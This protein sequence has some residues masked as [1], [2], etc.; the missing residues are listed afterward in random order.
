MARVDLDGGVHPNSRARV[1]N[2]HRAGRTTLIFA[3]NP[4]YGAQP[5]LLCFLWVDTADKLR[6]DRGGR[7]HRR[8]ASRRHWLLSVPLPVPPAGPARRARQPCGQHDQADS[9][10]VRPLPNTTSQPELD[11]VLVGVA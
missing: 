3:P 9:E 2:R 4:F 5:R 10:P 6:A 8:P 11:P 7:A 1:P